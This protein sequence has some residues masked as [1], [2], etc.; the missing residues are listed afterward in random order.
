M[1]SLASDAASLS[2]HQLPVGHLFHSVPILQINHTFAQLSHA[3][4]QCLLVM[5]AI[6]TIDAPL[7]RV[8]CLSEII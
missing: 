8:V 6:L 7:G 3:I 2:H 4:D 1:L 5:L